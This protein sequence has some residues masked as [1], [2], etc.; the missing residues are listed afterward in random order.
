MNARQVWK[1]IKPYFFEKTLPII[2]I[3]FKNG[4]VLQ[5]S[6]WDAWWDDDR[7]TLWVRGRDLPPSKIS[8]IHVFKRRCFPE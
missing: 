2:R 8:D 5:T 1:V 7:F 6:H 4:D 3:L